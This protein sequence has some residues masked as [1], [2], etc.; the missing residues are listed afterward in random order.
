M[1]NEWMDAILAPY[2]ERI[3]QQR[4]LR[5]WLRQALRRRPELPVLLRLAAGLFLRTEALTGYRGQVR[6]SREQ[7]YWLMAETEPECF[8]GSRS[9]RGKWLQIA[10]WLY[11]LPWFRPV[12]GR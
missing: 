3:E 7:L 12:F 10:P 5:R 9:I 6:M 4:G 2:L 1:H 8:V 11:E